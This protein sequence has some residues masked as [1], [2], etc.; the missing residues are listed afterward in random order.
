MN[1]AGK[2]Y[3]HR[4]G[5]ILARSELL[6]IQLTTYKIRSDIE[7]GERGSLFVIKTTYYDAKVAF[8]CSRSEKNTQQYFLN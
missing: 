6:Y 4:G 5:F 3:I 8:Q 7:L 1:V 2:L